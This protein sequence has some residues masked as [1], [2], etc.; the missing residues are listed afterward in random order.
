MIIYYWKYLLAGIVVF[1]LT[2][3]L[4][5]LNIKLAN[6]KGWLDVPNK[7]SSHT[8]SIPISGGLAFGL[9]ISVAH[10][11]FA[12]LFWDLESSLKIFALAFINMLILVIGLVDDV[13]LLKPKRKLLLQILV[14]VLLYTAGFRISVLTNPFGMDINLGLISFPFTILWFLGISNAINLIDGLDGLAS[15]ITAIS[16]VVLSFV[17]LLS[18]NPLVLYLAIV[19]FAGNVAFLKYNFYPAKIF[20]GDTGSLFNGFNLAVLSVTGIAQFKGVTAMTIALPVVLML[21][22]LLDTF[23]AIARRLKNKRNIFHADKEH[24]HHKLSNLGLS[25][26]TICYIAYFLTSL[27]GLL[28]LGFY[29]S[30]KQLFL[31]VLLV[32]ISICLAFG[33]LLF[34]SILKKKQ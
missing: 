4:V 25:Q 2:L 22:P 8:K 31:I 23:L 21:F 17:G 5:P 11:A 7:R 18:L 32:V 29:F 1:F 9:V 33:W 16:C 6:K 12:F 19:L 30:T 13:Y 10:L 15:G 27:F 14:S 20:M 34:N 24:I 26:V 3:F 28:A